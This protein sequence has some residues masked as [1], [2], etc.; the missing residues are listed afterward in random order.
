MGSSGSSVSGYVGHVGLMQAIG[1]QWNQVGSVWV[2][3]D[4]FKMS[5]VWSGGEVESRV[6]AS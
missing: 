3:L 4:W 1:I 5:R 2:E 6:G